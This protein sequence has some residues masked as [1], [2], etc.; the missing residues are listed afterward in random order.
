[1]AALTACGSSGGSA[2]ATANGMT[3][4]TVLRS[5]GTT[6]EG[7][8]IAQ[9][10]GFFKKNGLSVT[11]KVG[12]QDTSQDIPT[13]LRGGAQ[14]SMVDPIGLFKAISQGLKVEGM[15]NIQA[16]PTI[17]QGDGVLVKKDSG[18]T[19]P[20]D[21]VGKTIGI[22]ALGNT[23]DLSLRYAVQKDGGDP[24]KLKFVVLP[25]ASLEQALMKGQVD[26]IDT[27]TPYFNAAI[28]DGAVKIGTGTNVMP[29][30]PQAL[31]MASNQWLDSNPS[32]A[33]KFIKAMQEGFAYANSHPASIR[34]IDKEYTTLPSSV[35]E[36][37]NLPPYSV[38][39]D[40]SAVKLAAKAAYTYGDITKQIDPDSTLWSGAPTG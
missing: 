1:M 20:R 30:L 2:S 23:L 11:I 15:A 3:N 10:Q 39:L 24:S 25:T 32:T 40:A 28:A 22:P 31:F 33:R 16:A 38:T 19:R 9:E 14:L 29:G 12:A 17:P 6:F 5:T 26:A 35:I 4:I 8:Y 34:A 36:T 21:L 18:I 27:F 37:R 7:L 13:L